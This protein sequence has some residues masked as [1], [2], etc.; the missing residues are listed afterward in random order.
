MPLFSIDKNIAKPLAQT[1]FKLEKD[2]QSLVE[3]SLE[4]I[5]NCRFV[6]NEF[7]TGA[8]HA[9]RIDTLAISEDNNPVIIE[10]KKVESSDLINQSLFYLSWIYDHK[11]DFELAAKKVLGN[12]EEIDWSAIRVICIA[13]NFKKYDLH[14]VKMMEAPIELWAYKLFEGGTLYLEEVFQKST[15]KELENVNSQGVKAKPFIPA[16]I[17]TFE[18]HIKNK[19]EKMVEIAEAVK[20]FVLGLDDSIEE[21]PKKCYVAYR[22]SQNILCLEIMRKVVKTYLKIDPATVDLI[23][24]FSR[25]MTNKGHYGTGDL[26]LTLTTMEDFEKAKPYIERAHKNIG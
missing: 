23:D 13:P 12:K 17:H 26:E 3:N 18:S 10:Y 25:D 14:A 24:G 19:P 6:A 16:E 8:Q 2:L 15:N 4:K 11:G 1:N 21:H 9:G 20:E 22:T 5:F 7:S